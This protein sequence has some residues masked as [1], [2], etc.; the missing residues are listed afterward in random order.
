MPKVC[1][2][3]TLKAHFMGFGRWIWRNKGT[4]GSGRLLDSELKEDFA[5]EW[6]KVSVEKERRSSKCFGEGSAASTQ[7]L[8]HSQGATTP[9]V[10]LAWSHIQPGHL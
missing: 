6:Y 10:L 2:A 4:L 1:A 9:G 5:A 7:A 3:D 8:S